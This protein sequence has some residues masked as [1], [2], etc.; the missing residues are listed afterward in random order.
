MPTIRARKQSN[1][2]TRYHAQV[3]IKGFPPRTETLPTRAAAAQWAQQA[4]AELRAGTYRPMHDKPSHTVTQMIDRYTRDVLPEKARG[5]KNEQAALLWWRSKLGTRLVSE[6]TPDHIGLCRDE[7]R[8]MKTASGKVM[9]P[10]TVLRYLMNLSHCFSTAVR[11]WQWVKSSPVTA[12][13]KPKVRNAR[14]RYLNELERRV[15]LDACTSSNNPFLYTVVVVA[16]STGMRKGEIMG[17]RWS[18][19]T[20]FD[21]YA[22]LLLRETKNGEDR[23][24]MLVGHALVSLLALRQGMDARRSKCENH[25]APL[26]KSELVFPSTTNPEQPVDLRK[27]WEAAL[28]ASGVKDFRFHDLRHTAAS[29]LA[30]GGATTLDIKSVLGHKSTQMAERYSHLSASHVDAVVRRMNEAT[31][32]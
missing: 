12:V 27:P 31:F 1:G 26:Q 16:I 10:A 3:R 5:G 32:T 13:K 14:K 2:V 17:M 29:Y 7:L 6:V 18:D 9:A 25:R 30:M 15:L 21:G 20:F 23:P 8:R 19:I 22:K 28:A 4:E 11:E 24:V